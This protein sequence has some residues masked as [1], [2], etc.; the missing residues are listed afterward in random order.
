[1]SLG[2]EVEAVPSDT[3]ASRGCDASVAWCFSPKSITTVVE[4][5]E[6]LAH[7]W[8]ESERPENRVQFLDEVKHEVQRLIEAGACEACI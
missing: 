5:A 3:R 2:P 8:E 7:V 1:M 4:M 6:Q